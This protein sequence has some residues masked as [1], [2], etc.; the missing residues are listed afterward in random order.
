LTGRSFSEIAKTFVAT[1]ATGQ[2]ASL[3]GRVV[4]HPSALL[5]LIVAAAMLSVDAV[6]HDTAHASGLL[7]TAHAN[8]LPGDFATIHVGGLP[9]D[10]SAPHQ[11]PAA[12]GPSIAKEFAHISFSALWRKPGGSDQRE[13]VLQAVENAAIGLSIL[14]AE[15][16]FD[17]SSNELTGTVPVQGSDPVAAPT[18]TF[19][20][21]VDRGIPA[22][23]ASAGGPLLD[24]ADA[25]P[26]GC[27]KATMLLPPA[28]LKLLTVNAFE[29]SPLAEVIAPAGETISGIPDGINF[30]S[31]PVGAVPQEKTVSSALLSMNS[32]AAARVV[33]VTLSSA[34]NMVDLDNF[35]PGGVILIVSGEGALTVTHATAVQLIEVASGT[36]VDVTLS[37][38]NS[39]PTGTVEQ[40]VTLNGGTDVSIETESTTLAAPSL[41]LAVDSKG[42]QPNTLD[43]VDAAKGSSP[44]LD[45]TVT[46][47]QDLALNESASFA[48]SS[49]LDASALTGKLNVGIDLS[50]TGAPAASLSLGANNFLVTPEDTVA[51][52]NLSG[53]PQFE[54]GVNLQYVLF[55]YSNDAASGSPITLGINLGSSG[56]IAS[57]VQIG[58]L[59]AAAVNDLTIT[60]SNGANSVGAIDD[61]DLSALTL[62]GRSTLDINSIQ[63]IVANDSQNVLIDAQNFHGDLTLNATGILDTLAGGRQVEINTGSGQSSVTDTNI[64]EYLLLKIGSGAAAVNIGAGAEQVTIAGLGATDQILV[65]SGKVADEFTNGLATLMP[66]QA[67]IDGSANLTAAAALAASL[68]EPSLPHEALLFSYRGNTYVFVDGSG[69]HVFDPSADAIVKV[70]GVTS[71]TDLTGVFHST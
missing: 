70:V 45:V 8:G 63:G 15:F 51:F 47:S 27:A 38:D 48:V 19:Q 67:A 6:L 58:E 60:S 49:K 30:P 9:K 53:H 62:T 39:P 61:S 7:D 33:D 66:H 16:A 31:G 46:G 59:A 5:S 69:S 41:N 44:H 20:Y 1:I 32:D 13:P 10:L 35:A 34:V 2:N 43:L 14:A 25:G 57:P 64:T 28:G 42:G 55:S 68:G 21:Y 22:D 23:S 12:P 17:N 52:L 54:L 3:T 18:E 56:S 26:D 11:A 29:F 4:A 24:L 40:T 50:N 65:G 71:S 37:F 36:K